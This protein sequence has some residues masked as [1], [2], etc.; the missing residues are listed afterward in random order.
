MIG[1]DSDDDNAISRAKTT[2]QQQRQTASSRVRRSSSIERARQPTSQP[3][4]LFLAAS[5]RGPARG[6][7]PL[8]P[9]KPYTSRASRMTTRVNHAA[10]FCQRD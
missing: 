2:R 6:A 9:P 5:Q 1:I 10:G 8:R 7:P 3:A 4:A